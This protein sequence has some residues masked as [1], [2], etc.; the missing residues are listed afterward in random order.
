[1]NSLCKAYRDAEGNELC[2]GDSVRAVPE[3]PR[4]VWVHGLEYGIVTSL[5]HGFQ[6]EDKA[7]IDMQSF[8]R[9]TT[10]S[11]FGEHQ[12]SCRYVVKILGDIA[13]PSPSLSAC[14]NSVLRG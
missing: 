1:M 7:M 5:Y 6:R 8:S 3:A 12:A 9:S 4:S 14:A 10:S 2:I 11:N 13:E